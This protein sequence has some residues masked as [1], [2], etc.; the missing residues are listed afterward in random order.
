ML[1]NGLIHE[2]ETLLSRYDAKD[3][4]PLDSIGYGQVVSYLK[5]E[6]IYQ[7]MIDEINLRTRQYVKKQR[8]WFKNEPIDL[9]LDIS[10]N[11]NLTE[12]ISVIIS[13]FNN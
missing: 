13:N 4:H 1:V 5:G 10:N 3:V 2:V 11:T 7:D 8:T 6:L 12:I 9:E